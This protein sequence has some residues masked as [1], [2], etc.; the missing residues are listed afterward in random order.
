PIVCAGEPS[1]WKVLRRGS[2]ERASNTN[3]VARLFLVSRL[4]FWG[5]MPGLF[6]EKLRYV[7]QQRAVTQ[8]QLAERLALASH[9]HIANLEAGRDVPSLELIVRIAQSLDVSTDFFLRDTLPVENSVA[10]VVS[11]SS[12]DQAQSF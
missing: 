6:A 11:S 9:A 2:L 8:A 7:R 10:P 4:P 3:I 1:R 5:A 12:N